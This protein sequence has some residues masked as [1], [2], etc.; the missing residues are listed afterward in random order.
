VADCMFNNTER[1]AQPSHRGSDPSFIKKPCPHA[2]HRPVFLTPPEVHDYASYDQR[3]MNPFHIAVDDDDAFCSCALQQEVDQAST[4]SESTGGV[5]PVLEF[6][7]VLEGP[8]TVST[9]S[10]EF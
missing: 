3:D 10:S 7:S 8:V 9:V 6:N 4:W 2:F 5:Q 1:N